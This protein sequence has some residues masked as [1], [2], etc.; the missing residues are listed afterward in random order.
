M[1]PDEMENSKTLEEIV[2]E[3][4]V[5]AAEAYEFVKEGLSFA[6]QQVHGPE[7]GDPVSGRHISGQQLCEGLRE[8]ALARWGLLAETVLKRWGITST[9]DFG[10]IVYVLIQYNKLQKTDNDS[11]EDFRNVYDFRTAFESK[12]RIP[13]SSAK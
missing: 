5:Y 2:K 11:I 1:P 6:V 10:R 13:T 12:Y 8:Y 9:M 3:V 7:G 4:G